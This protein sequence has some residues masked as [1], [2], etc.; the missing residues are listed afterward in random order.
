MQ[1]IITVPK[2]MSCS[3]ESFSIYLC[4]GHIISIVKSLYKPNSSLTCYYFKRHYIVTETNNSWGNGN[5]KSR[6]SASLKTQTHHSVQCYQCPSLTIQYTL[7][8]QDNGDME[9]NTIIQNITFLK[10]TVD[11]RGLLLLVWDI[12]GLYDP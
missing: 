9:Q 2:V 5:S 6:F 1:Q 3:G 12:G 11:Y 8:I 4:E 10:R 7:T